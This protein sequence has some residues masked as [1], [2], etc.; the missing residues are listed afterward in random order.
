MGSRV[1]PGTPVCEAIRCAIGHQCGALGRPVHQSFTIC[2]AQDL[3]DFFT[4]PL[5]IPEVLPQSL[6][7]YLIRFIVNDAVTGNSV[8]V[9]Q[10]LES[11]AHPGQAIVLLDVDAYRE[12]D[13]LSTDQRIEEIFE[14]LR[15]LKNRAFF[16]CI[17]ERTAEMYE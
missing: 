9:T 7:G 3:A 8:I 1:W 5:V 13:I 4:A 6:R 12:V 15:D 11:T 14:T 16:G 2:S 17:T 10:A